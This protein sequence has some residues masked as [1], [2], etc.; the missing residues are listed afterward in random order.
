MYQ[1][2]EVGQLTKLD[3]NHGGKSREMTVDQRRYPT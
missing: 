3:L 2:L 1:G